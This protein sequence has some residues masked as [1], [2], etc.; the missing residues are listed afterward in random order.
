MP[1]WQSGQLHLTVNQASLRLRRFESFTRHQIFR[2]GQRPMR[3]I[4]GDG[5]DSKAGPSVGEGGG[6]DGS[7]SRRRP[8]TESFIL[9]MTESFQV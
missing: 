4:F 9:Y 1:G 7:A 8:V 3:N 6:V 2:L 5:K